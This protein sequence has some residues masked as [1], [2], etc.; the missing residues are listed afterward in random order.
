VFEW[1]EEKSRW[2]L[3]NRGF[4]FLYAARI[5][6]GVVMEREDRRRDYG[7]ARIVAVGSVGPDVLTVVYTRRGETRRVISARA[8]NRKE[9]DEYRK[10]SSL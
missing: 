10:V 1:D 7:E 6:D 9:R 3:E 8:A 5:F 2:N 4:D